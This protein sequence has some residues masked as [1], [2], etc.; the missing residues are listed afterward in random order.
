MRA[1]LTKGARVHLVGA[2]LSTVYLAVLLATALDIGFA[3]DEGFYFSAARS[4]QRWFDVL[5]DEPSR[6]LTKAV[7]DK[8]WRY[9]HEHPALMKTLFGFSDRV[10]NKGLGILSP[11]TAM[12]LPGMLTAALVVYLLFI[13]GAA[14]FGPR[15]GF[16]AA[17]F[18]ALMPRVF[19]HAHLTCFDVPITCL[20]L[21]VTYLYW[22]SLSSKRFGVAA[23]AVFGIA[24]CTKL[25]A[26]FIPFLLG[27]HYVSLLI[28]RRR[29]KAAA[30]KPWAFVFGAVLAPVIFLA[31]WPWLWTDTL[32]RLVNYMGFHS[33]HAHYN[34]AWLG[35]NIYKAPTPVLLPVGMTLF[36]I[37]TT[38]IVLA[39]AGMAGRLRHHLPEKIERRIAGTWRP[40]GPASKDGLDLL[41]IISAAFPIAL[42]SLPNVPIFGGTKHWMPAFPFIALFAGAAASRLADLAAEHLRR[43][44][45]RVAA[46]AVALLL[47]APPL[48]QTVTSHPFG[49]ESYVPFIGGAPGA[50]TMGL[51]RQFWGYTTRSVIPW[52]HETYPDGARVEIHDTALSAFRMYHEDGT[53]H[54]NIH[55]ARLDRSN[56]ALLHHEL[57]MV[58]AEAWIWNAYDTFT[59]TYVLT[60]HGVPIVSV[61]TR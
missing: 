47:L 1:L 57:H 38:V 21:A 35:Q 33:N 59:P 55:A 29:R 48:Q 53:L 31:H 52:L 26:F 2:G 7:I 5:G 3:R 34:T 22:R 45:R 56:V 18:F 39:V 10:F 16:F 9:N 12:R 44:P 28:H 43:V 20:W 15:A 50:A 27:L 6:A 49:L 40:V 4:Y 8:H 17:A 13:F 19:Y 36:T 37:P 32:Q 14:A 51:T 41:L 46:A 60:Y 61:Y 23:G 24:L 30:P 58:L 11:S 25:N 42:I 54:R